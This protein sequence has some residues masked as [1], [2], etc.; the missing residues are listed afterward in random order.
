MRTKK[1]I[2]SEAAE[3]FNF[4]T[5]EEM[6]GYLTIEIRCDMR[7][8]QIAHNH[9]MEQLAAGGVFMDRNNK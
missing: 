8:E 7:D 9:R 1:E 2:M 4:D 6:Q 3:P 5:V